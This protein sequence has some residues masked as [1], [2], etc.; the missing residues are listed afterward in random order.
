MPVPPPPRRCPGWHPVLR[1]EGPWTEE[2]AAG[3]RNRLSFTSLQATWVH[4]GRAAVLCCLLTP[5]PPAPWGELFTPSGVCRTD[6]KRACARRSRRSK[7]P[8]RMPYNLQVKRMM[9]STR[10]QGLRCHTFS[11]LGPQR[12]I[13]HD[14]KE[15]GLSKRDKAWHRLPSLATLGEVCEYVWWIRIHPTFKDA[16]DNFQDEWHVAEHSCWSSKGGTGEL[17]SWHS[18]N[19]SD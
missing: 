19:E 9:A 17:P 8:S 14:S 12:S 10:A 3:V 13:Q 4:V 15:G 5:A 1:T 7:E 6:C 16:H 2:R 18:G 11:K